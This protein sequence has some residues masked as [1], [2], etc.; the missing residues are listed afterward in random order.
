MTRETVAIE[1]PA[2]FATSRIEAMETSRVTR[3]T[4]PGNSYILHSNYK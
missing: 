1:T 3:P 4:G 2:S